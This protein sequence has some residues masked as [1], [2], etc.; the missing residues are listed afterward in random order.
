MKKL[1]AIAAVVGI[2]AMSACAG[3]DWFPLKVAAVTTNTAVGSAT[4]NQYASRVIGQVEGIFFDFTGPA[5]S[6]CTV[7]VVTDTTGDSGVAQT[8]FTLDLSADAYYSIRKQAVNNANTSFAELGEKYSLLR[9]S[10]ILKAYA[11]NTGTNDLTAT[12]I[13]IKATV[14]LSQ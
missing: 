5:L 3:L 4:T 13:A 11:A 10:V 7:A 1:T 14:V 9:D 2:M 6:T 8:L 12:T